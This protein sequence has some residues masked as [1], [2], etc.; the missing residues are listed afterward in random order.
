MTFSFSCHHVCSFFCLCFVFFFF[1]FLILLKKCFSFLCFQNLLSSFF[2]P[3]HSFFFYNRHI[4]LILFWSS[5]FFSVIFGF[6]L[7]CFGLTLFFSSLSTIANLTH[8]LR[9][10][11]PSPSFLIVVFM[12]SYE[13]TLS[14][15]SPFSLFLPLFSVHSMISLF[16][17]CFPDFFPPPSCWGDQ[18]SLCSP[19]DI[20]QCRLQPVCATVGALVALDTP[21]S[22]DLK[23]AS[24]PSPAPSR[25][26]A[27]PSMVS[28]TTQTPPP[29]WQIWDVIGSS[30]VHV[31]CLV[32][33][34]MAYSW[35]ELTLPW[36][37]PRP[38][39]AQAPPSLFWM[40]HGAAERLPLLL[41][42]G[43]C[44]FFLPVTLKCK[45]QHERVT[46]P[47]AF[48]SRLTL[49]WADMRS[50]GPAVTPSEPAVPRR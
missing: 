8:F 1:W 3:L 4:S 5:V 43:S 2:S 49:Q 41:R 34:F 28:V 20:I 12:S 13:L 30:L 46:P 21:S 19:Y 10:I 40:W 32:L 50:D 37:Q 26:P 36:Q 6:S 18:S 27:P 38:P 31:L 22:L 11:H 45:S 17:D 47:P 44:S 16:P 48:R 42:S 25:A 24:T 9:I 39:A 23:R 29:A 7:W 33:L 15:F 14:C 35:M